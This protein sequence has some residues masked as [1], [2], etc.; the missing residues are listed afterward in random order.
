MRDLIMEIKG[1]SKKERNKRESKTDKLLEQLC[2]YIMKVGNERFGPQ[3]S[4]VT[5]VTEPEIQE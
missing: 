2:E 1:L 5:Q 4:S 3:P